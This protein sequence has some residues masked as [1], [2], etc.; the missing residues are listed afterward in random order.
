LKTDLPDY[1][2]VQPQRAFRGEFKSEVGKLP[3]QRVFDL[4]WTGLQF[5]SKVVPQVVQFQKEGFSFSRLQPYERWQLFE[6]EALRLWNIYVQLVRPLAIQRVGVRFINRM[7]FPDGGFRLEDY[8]DGA[9][10]PL[11]LWGLSSKTF[12]YQDTLSVP[13]TSFSVNLVR[14]VQRSEDAPST[15][16]V[17]LDIDVF[18]NIPEELDDG[19]LRQ[20]LAEMRWLKNKIF[21]GTIT[22]KTKEIFQ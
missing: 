2:T 18:T 3:E 6:D 9:V 10:Q 4:G 22:P 15:K 13:E 14:T 5:R 20:R 7:P 1:P 19:L 12:L 21:F 16:L 8:L 11:S 17:I